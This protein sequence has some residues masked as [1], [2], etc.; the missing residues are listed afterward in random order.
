[1]AVICSLKL[2]GSTGSPASASQV[3]GTTGAHHHMPG[4]FLL[5]L[6]NKC[7]N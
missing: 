3:A 6:P 5:G 4:Q 1:M 2:L 7:S